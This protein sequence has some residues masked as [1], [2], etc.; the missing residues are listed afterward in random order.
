VP[1]SEVAAREDLQ[2]SLRPAA[3]KALADFTRLINGLRERP[4]TRASMF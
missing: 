1:L 4:K 3:R 2:E